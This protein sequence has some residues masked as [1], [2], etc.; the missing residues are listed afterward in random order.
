[1][2]EAFPEFEEEAN[3]RLAEEVSALS[4]QPTKEATTEKAAPEEAKGAASEEAA[5]EEPTR[6]NQER[7]TQHL[8]LCNTITTIL[9]MWTTKLKTK[10]F[11]RLT[12]YLQRLLL[13]RGLPR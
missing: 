13:R 6:A 4:P 1:M 10:T 11:A 3:E 12:L 9:L 2:T 5:K 7:S 8:C